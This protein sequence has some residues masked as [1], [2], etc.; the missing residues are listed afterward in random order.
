MLLRV[1][2]SLASQDQG[3]RAGRPLSLM[4]ELGMGTVAVALVSDKKVGFSQLFPRALGVKSVL[5][6]STRCEKGRKE[7]GKCGAWERGAGEEGSSE[8][9][10]REDSGQVGGKAVPPRS[11]QSQR[12][13]FLLRD[14]GRSGACGLRPRPR[15]RRSPAPPRPALSSGLRGAP[16]ELRVPRSPAARRM[17]KVPEL[18]DTFLQAQP[19]PQVSPEAQEECCVPLL[20][21]S[22]LI[23]PEERVYLA[24]AAQPGGAR[25]SGER[26]EDPQLPVGV[27]SGECSAPSGDVTGTGMNSK[28]GTP[29]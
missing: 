12:T 14:A 18:E 27:K 13:A 6:P 20:G 9:S 10:I 15:G 4:R 11:A 1:L 23:Y 22:L 25:C 3:C 21:K 28:K 5:G 7:G 29:H 24:A 26:R 2:L 17:A 8:L 19:S 16:A